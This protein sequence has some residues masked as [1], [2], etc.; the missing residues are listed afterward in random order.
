MYFQDQNI[1]LNTTALSDYSFDYRLTFSTT[2]DEDNDSDPSR[3]LK[4][5]E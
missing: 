3:P 2:V 4:F 5:M 1:G